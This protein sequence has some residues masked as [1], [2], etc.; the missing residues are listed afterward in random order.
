MSVMGFPVPPD[1]AALAASAINAFAFMTER[2]QPVE[3]RIADDEEP[4]F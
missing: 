1:L 3:L 2:S 4:L